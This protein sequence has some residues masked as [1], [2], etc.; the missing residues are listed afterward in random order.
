MRSG[1][2]CRR[3]IR[4][5]GGWLGRYF[6]LSGGGSCGWPLR[7]DRGR[8]IGLVSLVLELGWWVDTNC[9]LVGVGAS[10]GLWDPRRMSWQR[11]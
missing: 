9:R 1:G 5:F 2:S 11:D 7:L 10:H 3:L 4:L 6:F 8:G